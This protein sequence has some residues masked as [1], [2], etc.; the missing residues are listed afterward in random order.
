MF[1]LKVKNSNTR[2]YFQ[3]AKT[4]IDFADF[5]H[6]LSG[7]VDICNTEYVKAE[8]LGTL[9]ALQRRSNVCRLTL[10]EIPVFSLMEFTINNLTQLPLCDCGVDNSNEHCTHLSVMSSDES[11]EICVVAATKHYFYNQNASSAEL[12]MYFPTKESSYVNITYKGW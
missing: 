3:Y 12:V 2:I 11:V 8:P 7:I 1:I 5:F 6:F 4:F 10:Q 9:V